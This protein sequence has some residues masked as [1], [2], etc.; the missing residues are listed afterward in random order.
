MSMRNF[1]E[2]TFR[3]FQSFRNWQHL[4]YQRLSSQ[5][6]DRSNSVKT[7]E[8]DPSINDSASQDEH[9]A[10]VRIDRRDA[11]G[12]H[13]NEEQQADL[14]EV[15]EH[16]VPS[17]GSRNQDTPN[18]NPQL[19]YTDGPSR[20]VS[21][22]DG[23]KDCL[24]ILLTESMVAML[25]DVFAMSTK[26]G[27]LQSKYEDAKWD[28]AYA[29]NRLEHTKELIEKSDDDEEQEALRSDMPGVAERI[30]GSVKK[31]DELER[32]LDTN[33]RMLDFRHRHSEDMFK[34]VLD[35]AGL[36]IQHDAIQ[37]RPEL[38]P[39]A[40]NEERH[41]VVGEESDD[42]MVS[43]E[44]LLR[45]AATEE[46]VDARGWYHDLL[47]RWES[48]PQNYDNEFREYCQMVADGQCTLAQSDFDRIDLY[49]GRNLL[50]AL[51]RAEIEHEN[52]QQRARVLGA[53]GND[54]DQESH[55]ASQM[56]DGYR[57]SYEADTTAGVDREFIEAWTDEVIGCLEDEE[58]NSVEVLDVVQGDEWDAE[59]VE[60]S[61]SI[62]LVETGRGRKRIDR[63]REIC[64]R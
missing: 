34:K 58:S 44:S 51:I 63:W 21:A 3:K 40:E 28:A 55:F 24:A 45:R 2:R 13:L 9:G 4:K 16:S 35:Q 20:I 32:D 25:N 19:P 10:S 61:D 64:R 36:Y 31:R 33:R 59:T 30:E 38:R 14:F 12:I 11:Q 1:A 6:A 42:S 49:N 48:R 53:L 22:N 15:D 41:S 5:T 7:V 47:A 18:T 26:V 57:E 39:G 54:I 27:D 52:T 29:Q 23:T 62:S 17:P 56:D 8:H 60:I 50:G 43:L 46:F 37:E